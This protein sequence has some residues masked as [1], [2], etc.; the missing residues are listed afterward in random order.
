MK[1]VLVVDDETDLADLLA[2]QLTRAGFE[3]RCA[4][5][6]QSAKRV[7]QEGTFDVLVTDLHL[8]DGDGVDV[9]RS[10]GIAIRLALTASS[11]ESDAKRLLSEG[12]A[13][14][15][16]KPVSAKVLV[17]AIN[18]AIARAEVAPA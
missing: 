5:A 6:L 15:L 3:V 16:T 2:I 11:A 10:V 13:A 12:F 9:A 4:D 7:S 14:V 17:D 1:R 8:P 18:D